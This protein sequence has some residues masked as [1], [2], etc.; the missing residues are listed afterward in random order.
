MPRTTFLLPAG[1][2]LGG[3]RVGGD[4]SRA[5]GRADRAR[6]GDPGRRAQLRRHVRLLPDHWPL[7]ALA[8]QMDVGDAAGSAWLRADPS[9]V[10]P[11]INGARLLAIGAS[12][13]LDDEDRAAFLP[14]LR[15][16]FGDAGFPID[17][18]HPARWYLRLPQGAKVPAFAEPADALGADLFDHLAEG[19]EG[20]RWRVLLGEAQVVLHNHPHNARRA[21][22]GRAPVNSLWFWGAGALPDSVQSKHAAIH[23]GDEIALALADAAGI[24]RP[25]PSVFAAGSDDAVFDLHEA[26]D[27]AALE[28]DWLLPACA[29]LARGELRELSLDFADGR[30]W[31]LAPGQRWRFW[32]RPLARL[33]A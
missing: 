19:S 24:A 32:R 20:R 12:L 11:D 2:R 14:A 10:R 4:L 18:P 23:S 13:G 30:T 16:L 15:P 28:R 25:L 7:A 22:Q 29:A 5:L 6:A 1:E 26:R 3:Q 27:L 17:A 21:E 8:R 31:T 33:D 9:Y